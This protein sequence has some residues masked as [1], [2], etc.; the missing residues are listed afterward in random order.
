M[1]NEAEKSSSYSQD[2]EISVK[3]L[4]IKIQG[5][6]HYLW[7]KKWTILVTGL[8]GG[9]LGLAYTF[10]KKPV[11][12]ASTTF[13]LESGDKA[14]GLSA[15]AGLASMVGIDLGGGGGGIF[16]GDNILELYKSRSMIQKTLLSPVNITSQEPL[17]ERYIEINKLRNKWKKPE[18]KNLKY[19]VDS[20]SESGFKEKDPKNKRLLDSIMGEVVEDIN[21]KYLSVGKPDKKL[22]II[23]VDVSSEDEEFAKQFNEELVKNVNDFYIQTKTKK[24][25]E[26]IAILQRKTDSVRKV[27]N[28]AIYSAAVVADATPNLNP[29]R[30]VQRAAP[31]QKAQFSAETNKAIL[32]EMVKNLEM[33]KM[34]LMR[35]TP[36]IQ[37]VDKPVYPLHEEKLGKVKGIALGGIIFGFL[38][39]LVIITKRLYNLIINS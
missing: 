5:W 10:I 31:V 11:Y 32:G 29:T 2:E 13:V 3:E 33:S 20:L 26:N 15:Y 27:M 7:S 23:K 16:Q 14:G 24:S 38:S 25:L 39:V 18:L 9:T 30:Q 4:I 37:V 36:L 8:I 12:T 19:V 21:Q 34:A 1:N 17:I 28:G 6:W 22:A 35:E